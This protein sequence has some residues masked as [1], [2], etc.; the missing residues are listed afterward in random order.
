MIF[1]WMTLY[2]TMSIAVVG[3]I[4]TPILARGKNR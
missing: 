1:A 4:L 3:M 2:T